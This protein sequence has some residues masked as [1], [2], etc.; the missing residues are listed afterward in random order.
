MP[1]NKPLLITALAALASAAALNAAAAADDAKK[2]KCYGISAAG[3]N[4]CASTGSNSCAGTSKVEF[5]K[6]AWKYVPAGSCLTTEVT[7]PDGSKRKGSL[8]VSKS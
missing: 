7:L 6:G 5:D 3:K 8:D 1:T 2:E 4:D